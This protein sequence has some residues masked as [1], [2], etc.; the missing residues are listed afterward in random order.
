[1]GA[2][3][4]NGSRPAPPSAAQPAPRMLELEIDGSPVS[5]PEGSTILDACNAAGIDTPTLCYGDT[6]QPANA[7]RVCV[8]ELEGARVLAPAC[9]RAA[10]PGMK[11]RTDSERVRQSRRLVMEFLGS[12]VDLSTAPSALEYIDRYDARPERYGP[13]APPDPDRDR[14][15]AGHHEEPDGQTAATVHSPPKI[16]N[17]L[18][19]R[20]YSKCILCYKCVDACGEQYQNTF[21]IHVAGRG[22]DARISTEFD[23]ELPESACV[24]C[25]NCIAV[26]PTGA[27]MPKSEHDLRSSGDWRPE[28]QTVTRTVCGYCG[29]GCNLDLVVQDNAIV[30]VDSPDDHDVTRGNLCVKGRFGYSHVASD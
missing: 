10:E 7:C 22:F 14:K 27:L 30:R 24:Y 6:L 18:Y 13:P 23:V 5:V 16:D 28:D 29:V 20:D 4:S 25:G 15:R 19:V 1:M 11:V 3:G 9:S 2:N 21:A 26:C 17:D 12:S 8:V